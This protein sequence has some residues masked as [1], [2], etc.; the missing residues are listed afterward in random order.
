MALWRLFQLVFVFDVMITILHPVPL[1]SHRDPSTTS[2]SRHPPPPPLS[3]I[4]VTYPTTPFEIVLPELEGK[5]PKM[6]RGGK[7]CLSAHFKP[8]WGKNVPHFGIAHAL[9]MGLAPW[10]AAEVPFMIESGILNEK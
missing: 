8:L 7:I 4:P 1:P 3:Q 5:T 10:L 6:Y 2:L 9:A